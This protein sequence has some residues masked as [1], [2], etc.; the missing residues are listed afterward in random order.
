MH[1]VLRKPGHIKYH[2]DSTKLIFTDMLRDMYTC[3]VHMVNT[4]CGLIF[5]LRMFYKVQRSNLPPGRRYL[6]W[7]CKLN[8]TPSVRSKAYNTY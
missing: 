6:S 8:D 2:L 3:K 5:Y 4:W 7:T 1:Y